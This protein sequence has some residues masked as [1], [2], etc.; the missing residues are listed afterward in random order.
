[1]GL[2]LECCNGRAFRYQKGHPWAQLVADLG[3]SKGR[4]NC[5]SLLLVR[6]YVWF[7]VGWL[8]TT[9]GVS[10]DGQTPRATGHGFGVRTGVQQ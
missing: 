10:R 9:Y 3:K 7:P 6:V 5:V 4:R 1:M 2:Q 8:A